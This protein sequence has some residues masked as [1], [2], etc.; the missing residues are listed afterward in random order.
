MNIRRFMLIILLAV[1]ALALTGCA[2]DLTGR[3]TEYKSEGY[4]LEDGKWQM[5]EEWTA[6]D[7]ERLP[8]IA[9][10]SEDGTLSLDGMECDFEI[11]DTYLR[12]YNDGYME[13]ALIHIDDDR[14]VIHARYDDVLNVIYFKKN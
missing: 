10:F 12:L 14:L 4:A 7:G 6:A 2:D 8:V 9:E 5:E 1:T 13:T 3:W 11:E